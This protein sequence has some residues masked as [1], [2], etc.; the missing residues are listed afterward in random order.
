MEELINDKKVN[1]EIINNIDFSVIENDYEFELQIDYKYKENIFLDIINLRN[2][3][4]IMTTYK[5]FY[6]LNLKV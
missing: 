2:Y 3:F 1:I 6:N 5:D 4:N